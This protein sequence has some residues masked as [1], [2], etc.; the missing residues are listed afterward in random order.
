MRFVSF[1]SRRFVWKSFPQAG[2]KKFLFLFVFR[3]MFFFCSSSF[4]ST[5]ELFRFTIENWTLWWYT[6]EGCLLSFSVFYEPL[7]WYDH[8]PVIHCHYMTKY[9]FIPY[10][11][12]FEDGFRLPWSYSQKFIRFC[13]PKTIVKTKRQFHHY[14]ISVWN[15]VRN[16]RSRLFYHYL[17]SKMKFEAI[18]RN[19]W[20][21]TILIQH[22]DSSSRT[23]LARKSKRKWI[24]RRRFVD[25]KHSIEATMVAGGSSSSAPPNNKQFKIECYR[26][27]KKFRKKNKLF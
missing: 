17:P 25:T 21:F 5:L 12:R 4:S 6:L 7:Q 3:N 22:F 19:N 16:S 14:F 20:L 9:L 1:I 10:C 8:F 27:K 18:I 15:F 11:L 2:F 13:F 26:K 23:T 24:K